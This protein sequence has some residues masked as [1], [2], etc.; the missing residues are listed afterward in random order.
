MSSLTT[1][2]GQAALVM[3][4]RDRSKGLQ[5]WAAGRTKIRPVSVKDHFADSAVGRHNIL[6]KRDENRGIENRIS[7]LE[8]AVRALEAVVAPTAPARA[9]DTRSET[10]S[11]RLAPRK[12]QPA[13]G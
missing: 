3:D 7:P 4:K 1:G 8:V 10:E 12:R 6:H 11:N 9:P 13:G 2:S 5:R